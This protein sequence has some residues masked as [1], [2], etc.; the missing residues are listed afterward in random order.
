MLSMYI[1]IP[2]TVPH[3]KCPKKLLM[4]VIWKRMLVRILIAS[5][6]QHLQKMLSLQTDYFFKHLRRRSQKPLHPA[7]MLQ[8]FALLQHRLLL[9]MN[10]CSPY[11]QTILPLLLCFSLQRQG[12]YLLTELIPET[13]HFFRSASSSILTELSP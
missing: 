10:V 2:G 6:L 1:H 4:R 7:P 3:L 13:M 12:S 8:V 5:P 9:A 11:L